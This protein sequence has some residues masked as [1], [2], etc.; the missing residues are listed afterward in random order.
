MKAIVYAGY[1]PADVLQ[2]KDVETPSP[3]DGEVLVIVY[4][5][6]VNSA[7]VHRMLGPPFLMR[8]IPLFLGLDVGW[9]GPKGPIWLR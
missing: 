5:A 8:S 2:L 4:A 9:R 1:G 7:D 6:S 3:K